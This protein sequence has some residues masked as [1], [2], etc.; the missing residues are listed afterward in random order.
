M[1][2]ERPGGVSLSV[3][4]IPRAGATQVAGVRDG[5]ILIRVAAAPVESAANDALVAFLSTLLHIPVRNI[6]IESGERG[7]NK[8]VVVQG[9]TAARVRE[10]LN[11]ASA[12]PL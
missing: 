7:R 8:R 1:I 3:R 9:V 6:A 5:R 12:R 10:C 4:V 11:A 2:T